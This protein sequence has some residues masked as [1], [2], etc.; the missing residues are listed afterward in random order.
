MQ[1]VLSTAAPLTRSSVL[2]RSQFIVTA[3]RCFGFFPLDQSNQVLNRA[4]KGAIESSPDVHKTTK[5]LLRQMDKAEPGD[6]EFEE[7]LKVTDVTSDAE[8]RRQKRAG[9]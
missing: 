9:K 2:Q 6:R 7:G 4:I 5:E 3:T 8:Y 1:R